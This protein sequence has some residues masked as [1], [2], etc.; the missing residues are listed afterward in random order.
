MKSDI[1]RVT[2]DGTGVRDA[3]LQA[4]KTAA[5]LSLSKKDALH[6]ALLTEEMMGMMIALVGQVEA[7][8][9]IESDFPEVSL[10]L[11]ADTRMTAAKRSKLLAASSTGKNAAVKGFMGKI[12]DIYQRLVEPDDEAIPTTAFVQGMTV[13]DPETFASFGTYTWSL[14]QYKSSLRADA[15]AA[16]WD[17]LEKSIVSKLADEVRVGIMDDTAEMIIIKTFP[18]E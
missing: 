6:L 4:E 14:T 17:E 18:N 10:H 3:R 12:K 8:F 13:S 7:D 5:F 9:W 11:K 16:E 15:N 2:N 1:I